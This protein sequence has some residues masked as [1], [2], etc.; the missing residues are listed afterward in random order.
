[1]A[2]ERE[3]KKE[4]TRAYLELGDAYLQTN[5]FQTATEYYEKALDIARE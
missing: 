4:Q 2:R 5:Q 1:M 3:D